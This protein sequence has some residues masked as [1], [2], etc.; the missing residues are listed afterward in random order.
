MDL[1]YIALGIFAFL[2]VAWIAL[3]LFGQSLRDRDE[4]H[5]AD[6]IASRTRRIGKAQA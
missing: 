1:I 2:F 6:L 3:A 5:F 4:R